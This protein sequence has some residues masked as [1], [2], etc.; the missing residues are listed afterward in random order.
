MHRGL[1]H[2]FDKRVHRLPPRPE[3]A[4]PLRKAFTKTTQAALKGVTVNIDHARDERA[5]LQPMRRHDLEWANIA[6]QAV[7]FHRDPH[8]TLEALA[9]PRQVRLNNLPSKWLHEGSHGSGN[10]G[11]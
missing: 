8:A 10:R 11:W 7:G 1:V 5:I 2:R 6:D 4:R 3:A 9:G